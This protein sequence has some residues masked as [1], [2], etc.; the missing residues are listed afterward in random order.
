MFKSCQ[1]F[2][3]ATLLGCSI[4][5]AAVTG[6]PVQVEYRI[7]RVHGLVQ[8]ALALA[9]DANQAPGLKEIWV[10]SKFQSDE[11]KKAVADLKVVSRSLSG[12]LDFNSAVS[13]R[14]QG[15]GTDSLI[16]IQSLYARDLKDLA[17]RTLGI[18]PI[19]EERLFINA[20]HVLEPVYNSLVW[21]VGSR[22]LHVAKRMLEKIAVRVK[23]EGLFGQAVRFYHG[24]WPREVPF[25]I[26]LHAIPALK[27]FKN[28]TTSTSF[29]SVEVHGIQT[30]VKLNNVE[31]DFGVVFHELCHSIYGSQ[32]T[33]FMM[34]LEKWFLANKSP[35]A[36]QA[37]AH[38]NEALATALGN[39]WAYEKA[40]KEPPSE[41]WYNEPTIDAYAKAIS[42][43][44]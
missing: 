43:L 5:F 4:S 13:S 34:E 19:D 30:G 10:R 25:V 28:S 15:I 41:S 31:D 23:L 27:D 6:A 11:V 17:L 37:Y 38:L 39:S 36:R 16:V 29:A 32:S 12:G 24:N 3:L 14:P 8:F 40:R 26:G 33:E 7:S 20:L 21:N 1:G 44:V 22:D 42:P 35:Y 9:D 18:L 2:L